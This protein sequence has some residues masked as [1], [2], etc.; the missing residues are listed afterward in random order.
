MEPTNDFNSQLL[1]ALKD[2]KDGKLDVRLPD[3][4]TG[5]N[6]EIADTFNAFV[7]QTDRL[8]GEVNRVSREIANE[9]RLGGLVEAKGLSGIWKE[10]QDN[11]NEVEWVITTEIRRVGNEVTSALQKHGLMPENYF[12]PQ[13]EI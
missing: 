11:M 2:L 1:N 7:V 8:M 10:V 4:Q 6:K 3:N 5:V 13:N 12:F 9:G